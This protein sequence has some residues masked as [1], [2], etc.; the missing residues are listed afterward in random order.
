MTAQTKRDHARCPRCRTVS[1]SVQCCC[2]RRLADLPTGGQAAFLTLTIGRFYCHNPACAR[3]TFA[4]RLVRLLD[5]Y[6]QRTRRLANAQVRTAL[7]LGDTP[8]ARLPPHLARP[9]SA[10]MLLR[11][12]RKWPLPTRS[13][14]IIVGI[15]D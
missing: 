7:T 2:H 9:T 4:E 8:A 3:R 12:I 11:G 13:K 14:P 6:A 5:R 15:D 1:R 10:T